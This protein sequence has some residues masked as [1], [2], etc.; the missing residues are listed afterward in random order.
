MGV[1][2]AT[3][4]GVCLEDGQK[5]NAE[6]A[7]DDGLQHDARGVPGEVGL[8]PHYPMVAPNYSVQ[9]Q[10]L[11]RQIGL[12]RKPG[13]RRSWEGKHTNAEARALDRALGGALGLGLEATLAEAY[14]FL[15]LAYA[16]GDELQLFGFSR[17]AYTARSLRAE[18]AGAYEQC[19]FPGDHGSVGGGGRLTALSDDALLWVA[20]G[21]VSAGLALDPAAVESW[22]QGCDCRA[23]LQ[24]RR[25]GLLRRLLNPDCADRTGPP[26]LGELAE[27]AVRRWRGDPGYRPAALG[28][29]AAALDAR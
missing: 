8:K 6:S 13:R 15:V 17:G 7:S 29:L 3:A 11:A 18:G 22:A 4:L 26:C 10:T 9:R 20:E 12:G 16:P 27:A 28:R 5:L 1:E 24:A 21:A 23:P 2:R 19:W 14:R 25:S